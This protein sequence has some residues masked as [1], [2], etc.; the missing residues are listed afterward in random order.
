MIWSTEPKW[1]L[2]VQRKLIEKVTRSIFILQRTR[3]SL[4]T[5]FDATVVPERGGSL[6]DS[7]LA[8]QL[9]IRKTG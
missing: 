8:K 2:L 1:R 6:L 5:T 3:E 7:A 4:S 9:S